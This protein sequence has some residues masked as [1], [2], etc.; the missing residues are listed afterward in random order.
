[1]RA[2]ALRALGAATLL[3]GEIDEGRR[4]YE[5]SLRE[6]R[7]LGDDVGVGILEH[8]LAV[9]RLRAGD[10]SGARRMVSRSIRRHRAAG[11][12]KGAALGT[13]ILGYVERAAGHVDSALEL[14]DESLQMA[15]E[16][17]YAWWSCQMILPIANL[18]LD[19]GRPA[20]ARARLVESIPLLRQIDSRYSAMEVLALLALIE[21]TLRRSEW[22]GR[23]WGAVQAEEARAPTGLWE[24]VRASYEDALDER[25]DEAFRRGEAAARELDLAAALDEAEHGS[26]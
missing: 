9:E 7:A 13:G 22:A 23:L 18:L 26:A 12:L 16:T 17:G 8:R 25:A 11:F 10:V 15:N 20:T 6:C 14:L 21:A 19:Q 2:R 3:T 4:L 24:A 1:M 5:E